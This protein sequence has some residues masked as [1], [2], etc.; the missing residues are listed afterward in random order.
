MAS[1][2]LED[3]AEFIEKMKFQKSLFGGVNEQSVWKKIDDLNNEYKS[4][5]EEQEIKYRTLLEERDL[6]IKK[7]KEKLNMD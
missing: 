1:R 7:L 5:F 4:V 2:S 3:I 6:E